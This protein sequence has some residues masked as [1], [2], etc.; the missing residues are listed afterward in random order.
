MRSRPPPNTAYRRSSHA[1]ELKAL[2]TRVPKIINGGVTKVV[3]QDHP[4]D[5]SVD[6]LALDEENWTANLPPLEGFV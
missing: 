6:S 5:Y 1:V 4:I 3:I 2:S